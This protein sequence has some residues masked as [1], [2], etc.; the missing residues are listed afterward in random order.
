MVA[1]AEDI[2]GGDTPF[3]RGAQRPQLKVA[4]DPA[5]LRTRDATRLYTSA[6]PSAR[7]AS[8]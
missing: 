2:F 6:A 1:V 5:E 8:A 7:R 3:E 4:V